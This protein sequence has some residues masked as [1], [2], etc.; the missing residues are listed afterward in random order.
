M[1]KVCDLQRRRSKKDGASGVDLRDD[2]FRVW[3]ENLPKAST[4]K[5]LPVPGG[6]NGREGGEAEAWAR[7]AR[8]M[9]HPTQKE[10]F[11][12]C[13]IAMGGKLIFQS[14]GQ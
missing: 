1:W 5:K 12:R 6:Q 14:I 13:E 11:R 7:S 3:R 4:K 8:A 10:S 9:R 2:G